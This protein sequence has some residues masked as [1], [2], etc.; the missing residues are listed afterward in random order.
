MLDYELGQKNTTFVLE[1]Q[2]AHRV[3]EYNKVGSAL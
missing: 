1:K 3:S 2:Y